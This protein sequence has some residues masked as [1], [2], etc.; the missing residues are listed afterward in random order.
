MTTKH[1]FSALLGAA[2]SLCAA[3]SHSAAIDVKR[4]PFSGVDISGTY[5]CVGND[6]HDGDF[7][8]T[9]TVRLDGRYSAGRH[10][11]FKVD[12]KGDPDTY[13]GSIVTDGHQLAMDFANADPAKKDFGVALATLTVASNGKFRIEKFYYEPQYMGASNG[14]ERC[15]LQ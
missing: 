13:T 3:S 4:Q 8:T 15:L 5:A 6:A 14:F 7:K 1:L 2:M 10:G 11:S 9:M 12:I